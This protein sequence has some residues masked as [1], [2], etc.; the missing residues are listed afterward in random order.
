MS[1]ATQSNQ[2]QL[3]RPDPD[4]CLPQ[5]SPA[6]RWC[7]AMYVSDPNCG[8]PPNSDD[9]WV[10]DAAEF[11]GQCKT[12]WSEGTIEPTETQRVIAEAFALLADN[13]VRLA[14]LQARLLANETYGDIARHSGIPAAVVEAYEQLFFNVTN[15]ICL[16]QI[17][18]NL[19]R[20][21]RVLLGLLPDR[22]IG[23]YLHTLARTE[24]AESVEGTAELLARLD[25]K[26]FAE[27][28]PA[29]FEVGRRRERMSRLGLIRGLGLFKP[30]HQ[31]QIQSMVGTTPSMMIA[32]QTAT[33][34]TLLMWDELLSQVP[35]PKEIRQYA[36]G[37]KKATTNMAGAVKVPTKKAAAR[38][39]TTKIAV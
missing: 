38:K 17:C 29:E 15:Q 20:P 28:L 4:A 26:T 14:I 25:G 36:N 32:M 37:L 10:Q 6:W 31:K 3:V 2:I 27:G 30:K 24:G 9:P 22:D 8:N 1:N 7:T 11:L 34:K 18:G 21:E 35:I 5:H 13:K 19:F 33:D 16:K 39:A 23:T 12:G